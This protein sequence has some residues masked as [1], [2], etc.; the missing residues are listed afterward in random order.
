VGFIDWGQ[1]EPVAVIPALL[2]N[3]GK[4][5]E[6]DIPIAHLATSLYGQMWSSARIQKTPLSGV[7]VF[8][9]SPRNG[10]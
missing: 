1:S 9:R 8:R 6:K 3:G 2:G 7:P 5:A 10:H 4:A